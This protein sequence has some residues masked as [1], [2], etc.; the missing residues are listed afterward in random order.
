MDY[1][2]DIAKFEQDH[3]PEVTPL[4]DEFVEAHSSLLNRF[5]DRSLAEESE[6]RYYRQRAL[7]QFFEWERDELDDLI[8]R[9]PSEAYEAFHERRLALNLSEDE[10]AEERKAFIL[11]Q[12][13]PVAVCDLF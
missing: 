13:T 11:R 4:I 6:R 7:D 9:D 12:E 3:R 10:V 2:H 8:I 5:A 1:F